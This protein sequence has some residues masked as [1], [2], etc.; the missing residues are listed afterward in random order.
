[1]KLRGLGTSPLTQTQEL[2]L[3]EQQRRTCLSQLGENV[4]VTEAQAKD[5]RALTLTTWTMLNAQ[6]C[7]N[8]NYKG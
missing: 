6:P 8:R 2:E 4:V 1:L 5:D 3:E 7:G